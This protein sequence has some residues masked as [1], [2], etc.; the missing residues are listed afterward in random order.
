M[1]VQLQLQCN[2]TAG[3]DAEGA[4]WPAMQQ[5][6]AAAVVGG[7]VAVAAAPPGI[8]PSWLA[9]ACAPS[10][11]GGSGASGNPSGLVS[12]ELRYDPGSAATAP[13]GPEA[14]AAAPLPSLGPYSFVSS[15]VFLRLQGVPAAM[16]SSRAA[17]EQQ[18][19][20]YSAGGGSGGSRRRR[21]AAA[22]AAPLPGADAA[23][24]AVAGYLMQHGGVQLAA[25]AAAGVVA[26]DVAGAKRAAV[27]GNGVCEVGEQLVAPP[28]MPPGSA[29]QVGLRPALSPQ[30]GWEEALRLRLRLRLRLVAAHHCRP[31][32]GHLHRAS[33]SLAGAL[34]HSWMRTRARAHAHTHT[35]CS[36]VVVLPPAGALPARLPHGAAAVPDLRSRCRRKSCRLVPAGV[37]LGPWHLPPVQRRLHVLY[38]VGAC[39]LAYLEGHA[40]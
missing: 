35:H 33:T 8:S 30:L 3:A 1:H 16:A 13:L 7:G 6:L 11:A 20:G 4:A 31:T 12:L 26:A 40:C 19:Q 23:A 27:C 15:N 2:L 22:P 36:Q 28:W 29:P 37:V 24:A 18:Q 5:L 25:L 21:L 34:R 9:D 39:L 14:A 32:R 17:A 38:W 10:L